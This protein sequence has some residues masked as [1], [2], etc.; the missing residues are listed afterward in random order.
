[1]M[2][3]SLFLIQSFHK[4]QG[5]HLSHIT[6]L[7]LLLRMLLPWILGRP[8]SEQTIGG[9]RIHLYFSVRGLNYSC[10]RQFI[11]IL[12]INW[13]DLSSTREGESRVR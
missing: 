1:M 7:S 12:E 13:G 3:R 6:R 9:K 2:S 5:M 11:G 8:M 10:S 4:A